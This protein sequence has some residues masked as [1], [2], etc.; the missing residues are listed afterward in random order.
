MPKFIYV[1][2][3]NR[4][5]RDKN[6]N[7]TMMSEFEKYYNEWLGNE[8][9]VY[10]PN[11][12]AAMDLAKPYTTLVKEQIAQLVDFQNFNNKPL[13]AELQQYTD[14]LF[15]D[16]DISAIRQKLDGR[17]VPDMFVID[18]HLM[19]SDNNAER[20]ISW[21]GIRVFN[22]L[23]TIGQVAN[24]PVIFMST[25]PEYIDE[26]R[27]NALENFRNNRPTAFN[28]V[29][30][31]G[32]I[33]APLYTT[34]T[35]VSQEENPNPR[36]RLPLDERRSVVVCEPIIAY[37]H[38]PALLIKTI[39]AL[40]INVQTLARKDEIRELAKKYY[41]AAFDPARW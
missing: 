13:D 24:K 10:G 8:V 19:E 3:D 28:Q 37:K 17:S 9:F 26:I 21:D 15:A 7:G 23:G 22:I 29:N 35:L 14:K 12:P 41:G 20:K 33:E 27:N 38:H 16:T 36:Y 11:K 34:D 2:D 25:T 30:A 31:D 5:Q 32:T 39:E 1:V 4:N 6:V 40:R 18:L